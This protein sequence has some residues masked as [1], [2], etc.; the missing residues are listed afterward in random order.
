MAVL[1]AR[2]PSKRGGSAARA[3]DSGLRYV[4]RNQPPSGWRWSRSWSIHSRA[5]RMGH[6]AGGLGWGH[7][8]ARCGRIKAGPTTDPPRT[9]ML[10]PLLLLLPADAVKPA[11]VDRDAMVAGAKKVVAAVT[12]AAK[13]NARRDRPLRGDPLT[14]HYLQAAAT[15]AD[16]LE[17]EKARALLLGIGVA[18]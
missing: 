15:A 14:E 17:K 1:K 11:K 18:L 13:A 5:V 12:A 7:C 16:K 3:T 8:A 9:P 4:S 6:L 2:S 10:L